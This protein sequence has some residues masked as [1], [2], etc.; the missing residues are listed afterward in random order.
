MKVL[1]K[2]ICGPNFDLLYLHTIHSQYFLIVQLIL[3]FHAKII[4]ITLLASC[5]MLMT[6]PIYCKLEM[7]GFNQLHESLPSHTMQYISLNQCL[8]LAK[9][10]DQSKLS[11]QSSPQPNPNLN[12]TQTHPGQHI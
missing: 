4:P 6:N 3:N 1:L 5:A 10:V 7:K 9:P 2:Y 12:L 8:Y 11:L